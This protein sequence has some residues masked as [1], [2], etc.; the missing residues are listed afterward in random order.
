[1]SNTSYLRTLYFGICTVWG[2]GVRLQ[3]CREC[4]GSI[5]TETTVILVIQ[6]CNVLIIGRTDR[7][8]QCVT[9]FHC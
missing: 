3:A 4:M 1:M 6:R 2:A 9:R 5:V 7:R 8:P